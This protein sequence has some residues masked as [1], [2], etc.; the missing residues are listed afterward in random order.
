[1]RNKIQ[2][3]VVGVA[4]I[5]AGANLASCSSYRG[6][7]FK[8]DG[9][10]HYHPDLASIH[11]VKH[12]HDSNIRQHDDSKASANAN[13]NP[14]PTAPAALETKTVDQVSSTATASSS[15]E[16]PTPKNPKELFKLLTKEERS[17]AREEMEKILAKKPLMK[18]LVM[19][20]F[21]K[22]DEKYP[23]PAQSTLHGASGAG[24]S[25]GE[26]LAIVA[27]ACVP[28]FFLGIAALVIGIVA[29]LKIKKEGGANWAK[30][31]AIVA[32]ALGALEIVGLILYIVLVAVA[33]GGVI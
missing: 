7:A 11:R 23:A 20:K 32:I 6:L 1:M 8:P 9:H 18:H 30:I 13:V 24:L 15:T 4:V 12:L 28:F 21:N 10:N 27:I 19:N 22:M 3:L 26:I 14:A 25:L 33:I 31:L 16:V 5:I 29:L 17:Q 2:L